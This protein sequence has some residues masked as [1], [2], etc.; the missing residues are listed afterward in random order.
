[1]ELNRKGEYNYDNKMIQR[2]ILCYP[3]GK[4]VELVILLNLYS[5]WKIISNLMLSKDSESWR[6]SAPQHEEEKKK[7][8]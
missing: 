4:W 8:L 3:V 2:M 1:M 5:E 7:S 6:P